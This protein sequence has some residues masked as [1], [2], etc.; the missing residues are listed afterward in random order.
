[1]LSAEA[2][3]QIFYRNAADADA[4]VVEGVMGL[5]DGVDGKTEAGSTAEIAKWLGLPVVLVVDASSMARSAAA[6]VHGYESFDP[7]TC[8]VTSESTFRNAIWDSLRPERTC[9]RSQCCRC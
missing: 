7:A 5:F 1:M 3:R 8:R 4:C 2:N 6:L 9:C